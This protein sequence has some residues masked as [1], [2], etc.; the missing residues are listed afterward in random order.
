MEGKG[1]EADTHLRLGAEAA[2]QVSKSDF[3]RWWRIGKQLG[4]SL[5]MPVLGT[6]WRPWW[7]AQG[8]PWRLLLLS[9]CAV[10]GH[11][12]SVIEVVSGD[13]KCPD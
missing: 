13:R 6:H 3:V 8:L 2:G 12:C 7:E 11:F 10:L 5:G 4:S 1:R 9:V